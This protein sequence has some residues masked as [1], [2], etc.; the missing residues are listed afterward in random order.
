MIGGKRNLSVRYNIPMKN[1]LYPKPSTLNP[2]H[3]FTIIE[4]LVV[5]A[6]IGILSL[7]AFASFDE[8]RKSSRDTARAA[9]ME[10]I[11]AAVSIY[12]ATY[13]EYPDPLSE[14]VTAGLFTTL[15]EDPLNED[16][17][18]YQYDNN[19]S[20]YS[21]SANKERGEEDIEVGNCED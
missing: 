5:I 18:V 9:D 13:G 15:P 12:A 14:L 7:V 20:C 16:E 19:G 17:Y 6:I 3:G 21:L 4:L 10:Q 2:R 11:S 1:A 8:A